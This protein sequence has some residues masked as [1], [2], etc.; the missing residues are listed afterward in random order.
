M[1]QGLETRPPDI[2]AE[3]RPLRRIAERQGLIAQTMAFSQQKKGARID[4][5]N[6]DRDAPTPFMTGEDEE[7]RLV[8]KFDRRQLGVSRVGRDDHGVEGAVTQAGEEPIGQVLHQI[9]RRVRQR[10]GQFWQGDR[11]QVGRDGRDDS[12]AQFAGEGIAR[13]ISGG[14]YASRCGQRRARLRHDRRRSVADASA[15]A[16]AVEQTK[17]EFGLELEDLPAQRR[18]ADVAR[19]R[20]PAEMAM[21]GDRDNIFEVSKVHGLKIGHAD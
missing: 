2:R 9:E 18:L 20:R 17:A 5:I 21:F 19:R 6:P 15:A 14:G 13:R 1:P 12:K 3:R 16:F 10:P 7:E 8:V 4:L 11:Q